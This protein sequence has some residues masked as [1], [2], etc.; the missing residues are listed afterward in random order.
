MGDVGSSGLWRERG[1]GDRVVDSETRESK[2]YWTACRYFRHSSLCQPVN[3]WTG[4]RERYR[5]VN[6]ELVRDESYGKKERK[7]GVGKR[8]NSTVSK[9]GPVYYNHNMGQYTSYVSR[10]P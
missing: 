7:T 1:L 3:P 2:P 10:V 4:D 5:R 6:S 9:H 8:I